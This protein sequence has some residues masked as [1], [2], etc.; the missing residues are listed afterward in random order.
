MISKVGAIVNE[1]FLLA[2]AITL[3]V[4]TSKTYSNQKMD[5]NH[6][7]QLVADWM[8]K[9]FIDLQVLVGQSPGCQSGYEHVYAR[10]FPGTSHGCNCLKIY[11]P[12][13]SLSH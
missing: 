6:Q 5:T 9:P 2:I 13:I 11:G 12:N 4:L 7:D 10:K 1:L 3:V 8:V